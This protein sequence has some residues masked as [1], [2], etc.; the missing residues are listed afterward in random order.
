MT[1]D[2]T[3]DYIESIP[4]FTTK[5]FL[6]HTRRILDRLGHPEE[7]MK[8]IHVAGT[9]G[10]GSVC[11][12]LNSML[13]EGGYKVGLFTSPHLIRINERYQINGE[14][15]SDDLF[16][17][18]FDKVMAAVKLTMAEGDTHPTYFETLF[19]MGL[20]IFR[21][22]QVDY[23]ILEV[24]MGGRLDATNVIRHPLASIITSIS[25]DHT[26]Y[27]G[28]TIPEIAFEK[29]GIIKEGVP[30]IF[31]GHDGEASEVIRKRAEELG[32]PCYELTPAMYHA[33]RT[34]KE[35][36]TFDFTPDD[37]A[38]VRLRIPQIAEYQM[39][40]ASL[41]FFTM[42]LLE[43]VHGIPEEKLATGLSR[44][45]WPCRMETVLPDVIIDGAHNA[46]GIAEF[47]RTVEHFH[48]DQEITLLFSCVRDKRYRDMIRELVE[49]IHPDRVITTRISGSREVS[50]DELAELFRNDGAVA[51]FSEP[52]PERAFDLALALKENG[53][54][55]CVGSLYLAGE[56]KAYLDAAKRN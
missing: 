56:L 47:V 53:M 12:Y 20:L 40:N 17:E 48:K 31:D 13:M 33:V 3:V 23:T 28:D 49:G 4:K 41:A 36:V 29:A 22:K 35:G 25:L 9:N 6:D 38:A 51:V 8:I 39:M 52:S 50:E 11:A 7:G 14:T 18:A 26:E 34:T 30:V 54:L 37:T 46:D 21:E 2:E 16:T 44:M 5:T 43:K 55:F 24:G 42:K 19:L 27:L 32:A 15:V 1:Y 45:K 10:K